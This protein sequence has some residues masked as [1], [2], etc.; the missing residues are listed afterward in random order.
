[1]RKAIKLIS[2]D[3]FI[4]QFLINI[5]SRQRWVILR[6]VKTEGKMHIYCCVQELGSK[7]Q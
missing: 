6:S 4:C 5:D 2:G 7:V 1:M 3:S